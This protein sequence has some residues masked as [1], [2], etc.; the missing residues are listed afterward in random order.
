MGDRF[1]SQSYAAKLRPPSLIYP[2]SPLYKATE[3]AGTELARFIDFIQY[4]NP[5]IDRTTATQ[6]AAFCLHNLPTLFLDHPEMMQQLSAIA[7]R[8]SQ[9]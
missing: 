7:S 2:L 9:E 3:R 4:H 5:D 8:L 1:F 6:T